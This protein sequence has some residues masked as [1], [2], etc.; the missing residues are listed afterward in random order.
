MSVIQHEYYLVIKRI[1]KTYFSQVKVQR[2][3]FGYY[4]DK[5]I[6]YKLIQ[7]LTGY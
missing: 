4:A 1:K 5:K 2:V 6:Q 7:L 3:I